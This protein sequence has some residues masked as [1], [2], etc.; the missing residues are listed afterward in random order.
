MVRSENT[1]A[2]FLQ[3][4]KKFITKHNLDGV[5]YN[6]E[7]PGYQFG[8]GYQA[9]EVVLNEYAGFLDLVRQT[10]EALGTKTITL[11]YYPDGRQEQLLV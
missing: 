6:W 8:S 11:A 10:R 1:R 5:D 3:Q 7:Y 2:R 9:E 4:L